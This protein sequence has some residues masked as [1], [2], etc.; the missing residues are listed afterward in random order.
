MKKT[1][2]LTALL[3]SMALGAAWAVPSSTPS[4][5]QLR[6]LEARILGPAA[7]SVSATS[8]TLQCWPDPNDPSAPL[9]T[10]TSPT[11]NCSGGGKGDFFY[12]MC[13]GHMYVC[14]DYY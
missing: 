2:V 10:C 7:G 4:E 6:D 1:L 12:I 3:L 14:P 13:D 9:I 8:C 11:G 5:L